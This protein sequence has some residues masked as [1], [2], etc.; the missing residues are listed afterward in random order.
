[1]RL[2]EPLLQASLRAGPQ[3]IFLKLLTLLV[4]VGLGLVALLIVVP[5]AHLEHHFAVQTSSAAIASQ[6]VRAQQFPKLGRALQFWIQAAVASSQ[7]AR[8]PFTRPAAATSGSAVAK[9]AKTAQGPP[10]L[11]V[12]QNALDFIRYGGMSDMCMAMGKE[13]GGIAV[14][15]NSDRS[16]F[17]VNDPEMVKEVT[18]TQTQVFYNRMSAQ[19]GP[20]TLN[21]A[22]GIV[23]AMQADH[24]HYR[25]LAN[26]FFFNKRLL[27]TYTS[28]VERETFSAMSGWKSGREV[29]VQP[30]FKRLTLKVISSIAFTELETDGEQTIRLIRD[31]LDASGDLQRERQI[32]AL[33]TKLAEPLDQ[34]NSLLPIEVPKAAEVF[35]PPSQDKVIEMG[36]RLRRTERRIINARREQLEASRRHSIGEGQDDGPLDDMPKDLLSVL[37]NSQEDEKRPLTDGEIQ[38]IVREIIIAGSDTTA[39]S[40]SATLFLLASNLRSQRRVLHELDT[41]LGTD[42]SKPL[43]YADIDR[44]P[45]LRLCIKE[46]MRLYPAADVIFRTAANTTSVG[47]YAIPQNSG[48][49]ISPVSLGRN[50]QQW[51]RDARRFRPE[52][53][54]ELDANGQNLFP[55]HSFAWLP[56]GAGPRGCIGGRLALMEATAACATVLRRWELRASTDAELA[57]RYSVTVEFTGGVPVKLVTRSQTH[58]EKKIAR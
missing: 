27:E 42:L 53:F 2:V 40:I 33:M 48:M 22:S 13:Y 20:T 12:L 49:I 38:T 46:A 6:H 9:T 31:M 24:M 1:M 16:F 47:G 41:V 55:K 4:G 29:D 28:I 37:I 35:K 3:R 36:A 34:I 10:E 43:T 25:A 57:P 8:Q 58:S 51:G 50:E 7:L 39:S 44:L 18:S 11:P 23:S 52:R 32:S 56:F 30:V 21:N 15:R 26:P 14:A 54:E 19:Q 45:Y 17:F 5:Q